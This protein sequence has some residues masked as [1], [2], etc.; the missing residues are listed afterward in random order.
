M[1]TKVTDFITKALGDKDML[2]EIKDLATNFAGA[3]GDKKDDVIGSLTS[4]AEKYGIDL[5]PD[6]V[7]DACKKD[8]DPDD[9]F[10]FDDILSKAGGLLDGLDGKTGDGF[11][12]VDAIGGLFKG[13]SK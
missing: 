5:T 8:A 11:H 1:S 3:A 12:P 6:D 13:L 10:S 4:L 7:A 2:S 9:G